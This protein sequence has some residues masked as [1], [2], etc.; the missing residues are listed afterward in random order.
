MKARLEEKAK[1]LRL[2]DV[3]AQKILE[4]LEFD[5]KKDLAFWFYWTATRVV[6]KLR[7]LR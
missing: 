2:A 5:W 6:G 1:Q 3:R 7:L 4:S